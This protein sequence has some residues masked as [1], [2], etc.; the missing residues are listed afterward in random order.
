M[1]M[2]RAYKEMNKLEKIERMETKVGE[3]DFGY[4]GRQ[5]V[6]ERKRAIK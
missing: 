2:A 3:G 4:K 5:M 1:V 6:D